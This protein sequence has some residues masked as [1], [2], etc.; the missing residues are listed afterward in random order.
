MS[1]NWFIN[2]ALIHLP[3][4]H[5]EDELI[6]CAKATWMSKLHRTLDH[7]NSFRV[8]FIIENYTFPNCSAKSDVTRL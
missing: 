4:A 6:S 8:V 7:P 5:F 2:E 3:R 1:T